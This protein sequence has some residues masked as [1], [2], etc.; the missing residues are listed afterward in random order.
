MYQG[1]GVFG[2]KPLPRKDL[3]LGILDTGALKGPT[4]GYLG[5]LKDT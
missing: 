1:P 3:L 2:V 5:Y 4:F